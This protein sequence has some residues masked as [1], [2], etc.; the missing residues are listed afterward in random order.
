MMII[1]DSTN[2]ENYNNKVFMIY[3]AFHKP[4]VA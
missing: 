2:N 1:N 4:K 3:Y